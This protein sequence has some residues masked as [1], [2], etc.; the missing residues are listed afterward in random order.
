[1]GV[2]V[3]SL[4]FNLRDVVYCK[5]NYYYYS[6][7]AI[8]LPSPSRLSGCHNKLIRNYR[9]IYRLQQ[10]LRGARE[11]MAASVVCDLGWANWTDSNGGKFRRSRFAAFSNSRTFWVESRKGRVT[12]VGVGFITEGD[13][14]SEALIADPGTTG[15][16]FGKVQ[17]ADS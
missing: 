5:K 10:G 1:M 11:G 13:S 6:W 2:Y 12:R 14:E 4:T 17:V 7:E 3:Y 15:I 9:N 8:L 16:V